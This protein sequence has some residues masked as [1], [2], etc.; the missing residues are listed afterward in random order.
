MCCRV[1]I[2]HLPVPGKISWVAP[3][4][5]DPANDRKNRQNSVFVQDSSKLYFFI[6]NGFI[7]NSSFCFIYSGSDFLFHSAL[8]IYFSTDN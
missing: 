8:L 6:F 7:T 5:G 4:K 1:T 3:D 2:R